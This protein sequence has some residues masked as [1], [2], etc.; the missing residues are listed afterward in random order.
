[1]QSPFLY[2]SGT[3]LED[4]AEKVIEMSDMNQMIKIK[5]L[6]EVDISILRLIHNHVFITAGLVGKNYENE[7]FFTTSFAKNRMRKFIK[8]GLVRRFYITFDGK[9]AIHNRTVNFY[10]LTD[11]SMKYLNKYFGYKSYKI[12]LGDLAK[13]GDV[14]SILAMNQAII[15]YTKSTSTIGE[16]SYDRLSSPR[17]M[18]ISIYN[19]TFK[20]VCVRKDKT[21]LDLIKKSKERY[22]ALLL[23][24]ENELFAVDLTKTY[25]DIVDGPLF[26]ITDLMMASE[27]M[28]DSYLVVN[29]D[30]SIIEYKLEGMVAL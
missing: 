28:N 4:P 21:N 9:E 8:Y 30:V 29:N 10:S 19:K 27:D 16:V 26:F 3:I 15:N 23:L 17:E 24:V 11:A 25:K 1:M 5:T 2:K 12:G 20:V 14:L 22:S 7:P 18:I 6:D 13:V